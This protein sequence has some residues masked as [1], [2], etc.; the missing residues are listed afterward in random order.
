MNTLF[1]PLKKISLFDTKKNQNE[2]C[3]FLCMECY[4]VSSYLTNQSLD[5]KSKFLQKKVFQY[6]YTTLTRQVKKKLYYYSKKRSRKKRS[7]TKTFI[8]KVK[9]KHQICSKITT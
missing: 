6:F 3:F 7:Q 1:D 8:F 4:Y 2:S 9:F 5:L